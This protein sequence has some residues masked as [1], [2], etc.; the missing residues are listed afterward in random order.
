MKRANRTDWWCS[1]IA[2]NALARALFECR[3]LG[4]SRKSYKACKEILDFYDQP[5]R[6]D[7]E[8]HW[9]V[10]NG[11]MEGFAGEYVF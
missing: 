7:M 5:F 8:W 4:A 10:K 3:Y 9:F 6:W 1:P 2:V 11:T